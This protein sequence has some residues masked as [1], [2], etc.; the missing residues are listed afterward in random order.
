VTDMPEIELVTQSQTLRLPMSPIMKDES[1]TSNNV[2]IL[3][4][5][6]NHQFRLEP[7][8]P[9]YNT[10][11]RLVYGDLKTVK[12]ILA[13]KN[14]RRSTA[15]NAYDRYDWLIPGLGMWHLRFNLLPL[16][17]HIHWGGS[18]PIDRS[19]LQFAADRWGRSQVVEP[20]NFQALEDLIVHSYRS[21]VVAWCLLTGKAADP[22]INRIEDV[23][24]WLRA[25]DAE[26]WK[27][28]LAGI[29]WRMHPGV[30]S[31]PEETG[32]PST[33]GTKHRSA[34]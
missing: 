17:H 24:Q 4:N 7:S 5:I 21:R 1:T 6:Y 33:W 16:I 34:V 18:R 3:D 12:R 32:L 25:Q 29:F 15:R 28:L 30:S 11:L 27:A 19:T 23:A 2:A 10:Q 31:D 13:V 22:Q 20:N 14:L 8:D 9:V 26:S